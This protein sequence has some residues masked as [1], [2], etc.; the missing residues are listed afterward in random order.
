M[1][2]LL[3]D[4]LGT[5]LGILR[6]QQIACRAESASSGRGNCSYELCSQ[7]TSVSNK[8][9]KKGKK[10]LNWPENDS[11]LRSGNEG[12]WDISLRSI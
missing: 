4:R 6:M 2:D 9:K 11:K 12:F 7:M 10:R 8:K 1:M 3:I 5:L